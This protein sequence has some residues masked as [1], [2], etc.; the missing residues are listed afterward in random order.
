MKKFRVTRYADYVMGHLR[1]GHREGIIENA[2]Y[3][4]MEFEIHEVIE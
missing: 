2:S 3:D 4:G 1:D